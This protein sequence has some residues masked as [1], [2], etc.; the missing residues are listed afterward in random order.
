[1]S[2]GA[3]AVWTGI[4]TSFC[5]LW[6]SA[7][8]DARITETTKAMRETGEKCSEWDLIFTFHIS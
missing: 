6:V 1:M 2:E 4:S 7:G 3:V 8:N 5:W